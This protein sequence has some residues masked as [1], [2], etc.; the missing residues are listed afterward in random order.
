MWFDGPSY[1]RLWPPRELLKAFKNGEIDVETYTRWYEIEV[2]STFTPRQV[3]K[4]L[5]D[6]SI[7]LCWCNMGFCHR[8]LVRD[9]L[10]KNGIETEELRDGYYTK[11]ST[12]H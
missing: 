12:S 2:L 6:G 8:H 3:E 11:F 9:W 4:D 1:K 10:N 5:L 7:L